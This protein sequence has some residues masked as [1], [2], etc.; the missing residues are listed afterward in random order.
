MVNEF[1]PKVQVFCG[2]C[3]TYFDEEKVEFVDI[4]EN[5]QGEDVETFICPLCGKKVR[6]KRYG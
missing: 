6:S 2:D 1:E 5:M 4:E 3:Q